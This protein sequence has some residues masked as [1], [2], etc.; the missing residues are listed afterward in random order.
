[1]VVVGVPTHHARSFYGYSLYGLAVDH[2]SMTHFS[3]EDPQV[4]TQTFSEPQS[5]LRIASKEM[6]EYEDLDMF[7]SVLDRLLG[8]TLQGGEK[9]VSG[10]SQ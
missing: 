8:K 4:L 9:V 10:S 1:M 6:L 3:R 2:T 5:D 7:E